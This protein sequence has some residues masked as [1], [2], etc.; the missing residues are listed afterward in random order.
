MLSTLGLPLNLFTAWIMSI[1]ILN[2][3]CHCTHLSLNC[4]RNLGRFTLNI[5]YSVALNC[6]LHR[7]TS[8]YRKPWAWSVVSLYTTSKHST[9]TVLPNAEWI[10][11]FCMLLLILSIKYCVAFYHSVLGTPTKHCIRKQMVTW[12]CWCLILKHSSMLAR[13]RVSNLTPDNGQ[14]WASVT[15][16]SFF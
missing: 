16:V 8:I 15:S 13:A 3:I 9:D 2:T 4:C 7:T 12:I 10:W 1:I 11:Y 14:E 6:T 5:P